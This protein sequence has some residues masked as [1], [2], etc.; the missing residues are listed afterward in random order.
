MA[1]VL[2]HYLRK[3]LPLFCFGSLLSEMK[4]SLFLPLRDAVRWGV[5]EVRRF[6][7]YD[8]KT[9]QVCQGRVT[10][11]GRQGH[12]FNP[13]S[14][15]SSNTGGMKQPGVGLVVIQVVLWVCLPHVIFF[16]T[17]TSTP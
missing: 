16:I 10:L 13:T 11:A 7:G 15:A 9:L 14:A 6:L 17:G 3:P 2:L 8:I 12:S 4:V 5:K 1:F